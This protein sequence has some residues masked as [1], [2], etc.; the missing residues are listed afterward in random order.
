MDP[1]NIL[2]ILKPVRK[3]PNNSVVTRKVFV[4]RE[5]EITGPRVRINRVCIQRETGDLVFKNTIPLR[6]DRKGWSA[7]RSTPVETTSVEDTLLDTKFCAFEGCANLRNQV[8]MLKRENA[9]LKLDN[10]LLRQEKAKGETPVAGPTTP[11]MDVIKTTL[12]ILGVLW[13]F[14]QMPLSE[15]KTVERNITPEMVQWCSNKP[16]YCFFMPTTCDAW[17][18]TP[19]NASQG[20][21][22]RITRSVGGSYEAFADVLTSVKNSI[23]VPSKPATYTAKAGKI[24]IKT[25]DKMTETVFGP[26]RK[27]V[28]ATLGWFFSA[29]TLAALTAAMI[30]GNGFYLL[31]L[32]TCAHFLATAY[33]NGTDL[34]VEIAMTLVALCGGY[35]FIARQTMTSGL[36]KWTSVVVVL[37]ATG[38]FDC[39]VAAVFLQVVITATIIVVSGFQTHKTIDKEGNEKV[40]VLS[41]KEWLLAVTSDAV[42]SFST[43]ALLQIPFFV[44]VVLL[45]MWSIWY[46]LQ[47]TETKTYSYDTDSATVRVSE[48]RARRAF[49]PFVVQQSKKALGAVVT[50]KVYESAFPIRGSNGCEG[51]AFL[52]SGKLCVL[53][54]VTQ[55]KDFSVKCAGVWVKVTGKL[56]RTINLEHGQ[57]LLCYAPPQEMSGK[58][59]CKHSDNNE[60]GWM[61]VG[62][63][64][65]EDGHREVQCFYARF[66]NPQYVGVYEHQPGMSGAPVFNASGRIVA[67]HY[68]ANGINGLSVIIPL[69]T[70]EPKDKNPDAPAIT[71]LQ[72]AYI[73]TNDLARKAE[74]KNLLRYASSKMCPDEYKQDMLNFG[75]WSFI[76]VSEKEV[77]V[78]PSPPENKDSVDQ[79]RT[80]YL[81]DHDT[82]ASKKWVTLQLGLLRGEIESLLFSMHHEQAEQLKTYD[83]AFSEIESKMQDDMEQRKSL[84]KSKGMRKVARKITRQGGLLKRGDLKKHGLKGVS[85]GKQFTD[86][87]YQELLDKGMNPDSIRMMAI[88]RWNLENG[89]G[90]SDSSEESDE[91][92]T[93]GDH[94][95][96]QGFFSS[97]IPG[98][99]ESHDQQLCDMENKI[100]E[101]QEKITKMERQSEISKQKVGKSLRRLRRKVADKTIDSDDFDEAVE[102]VLVVDIAT[103]D[104]EDGDVP[105]CHTEKHVVQGSSVQEAI[106]CGTMAACPFATTSLQDDNGASVMLGGV[107][108]YDVCEGCQ[109]CTG[110]EQVCKKRP[111]NTKCGEKT[112]CY[113]GHVRYCKKGCTMDDEPVPREPCTSHCWHYWC[114]AKKAEDGEP[115][116]SATCKNP[117]SL[118]KSG[119][120]DTKQKK[121]KKNANPKN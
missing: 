81:S 116:T 10:M 56:Q 63:I 105:L 50:E 46:A 80:G 12:V 120:T 34:V 98:Q 108:M 51:Q 74:L 107:K 96:Q 66:T 35:G 38:N 15:G 68:A 86:D 52:F 19:P 4:L 13:F 43:I 31:Q 33:H 41:L 79:R 89:S 28:G 5:E 101:M 69:I 39:I 73:E 40:R 83:E 6:H 70:D 97:L 65:P 47:Y 110:V 115:C 88:E 121:N 11:K 55:G 99:K 78:A 30:V 62:Y 91:S 117:F 77:P 25:T 67:V 118:E 93:Y 29:E 32:L 61:M 90:Y 2:A 82:P 24:L 54:H 71:N 95:V 53:K 26:A 44:I 106:D 92:A 45:V 87:E 60:D 112:V 18:I 94:G 75:K 72:N 111:H 1:S 103:W 49:I 27:A 76:D 3:S 100:A 37:A 20:Y 102:Q 14:G 16:T 9:D 85:F 7:F 57:V 84:A 17:C 21:Y 36:S 8:Q 23:V 42:W 109:Y 114:H 104:W 58:R 48:R 119:R 22:T 59:N 64:N 113:T